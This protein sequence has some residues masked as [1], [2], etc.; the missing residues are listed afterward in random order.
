VKTLVLSTFR[1]SKAIYTFIEHIEI[2][3][4]KLQ[5]HTNE[6]KHHSPKQVQNSH[7]P[8]ECVVIYCNIDCMQQGWQQGT[9]R[10]CHSA[11]ADLE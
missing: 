3:W 1:L 9:G 4:L 2:Q 7:K 5:M 10:E 6:L 8:F 11:P